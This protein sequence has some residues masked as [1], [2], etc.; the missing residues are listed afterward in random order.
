VTYIEARNFGRKIRWFAG[1]VGNFCSVFFSPGSIS[2]RC[3]RH[4]AGERT[5]G[6]GGVRKLASV[7]FKTLPACHFTML[8]EALE[9]AVLALPGLQRT[10]AVKAC[11]AD[12]ILALAAAGESDPTNLGQ[13]ALARVRQ[14]CARCGGCEGLTPALEQ[15]LSPP[16]DQASLRYVQAAR[17]WN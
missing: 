12:N 8:K 3:L 5:L 6:N 13:C 4:S 17:R 9:K 10:S 1:I 14:S 7:E 15:Q 11:L 16:S 2:N